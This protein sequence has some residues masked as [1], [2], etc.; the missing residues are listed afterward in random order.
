MS[1]DQRS[2]LERLYDSARVSAECARKHEGTELSTMFAAMSEIFTESAR[3]IERL[4][5]YIAMNMKDE[6][7]AKEYARVAGEHAGLKSTV[8]YL[9]ALK[10]VQP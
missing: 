4:M 9:S 10:E 6:Q 8:A 1:N 3:E 5:D 2:L 7:L